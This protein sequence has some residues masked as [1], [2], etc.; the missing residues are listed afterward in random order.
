M[1]SCWL[2]RKRGELEADGLP[3]WTDHESFESTAAG[4]SG[5]GGKVKHAEG[6]SGSL[7][8]VWVVEDV[9]SWTIARC[10]QVFNGT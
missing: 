7:G 6:V 9:L 5:G 2:V 8:P 3:D 10:L 1:I 4:G